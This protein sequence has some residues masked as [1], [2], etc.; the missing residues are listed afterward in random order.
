MTSTAARAPQARA[1]TVLR[2]AACRHTTTRTAVA[3]A[4][5]ASPPMPPG[6]G[7]VPDGS[8][9]ACSATVMIQPVAHPAGRTTS[10]ATA[11]SNG[12]IT[13]VAKPRTVAGATAGPASRLAG[14]ATG[15]SSAT[16]STSTGV[17]AA[18]AAAGT[19][20]ASA[21]QYGR[22]HATSRSRQRGAS[23]RMPAVAHTDSAKPK[24][25]ASAGS[26]RINPRTAA[27][28]ADTPSRSRPTPS[29]RVATRPMTSAR[30]T[31]GD[32]RATTAKASMAAAPTAA[33]AGRG[34]PASRA[35]AIA[36]PATI[37]RLVPLTA[38]RWPSPASRKSASTC[39]SIRETSPA[40]RAGT[41][42]R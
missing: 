17:T 9:A 3:A 12:A 37:A 13:A 7:I 22:R 25:R 8:A 2:P 5:S 10:R 20:T 1:A 41:R 18:C 34:S 19:A 23:S 31:L 32:G 39:G 11:T 4:S 42:P 6:Q 24:D 30:S 33:R 40:T 16:M 27:D 38:V 15:D 14:T 36:A 26:N 21:S 35:S 28:S 29:A